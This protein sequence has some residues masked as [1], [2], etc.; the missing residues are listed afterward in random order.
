MLLPQKLRAKFTNR[1]LQIIEGLQRLEKPSVLD[2]VSFIYEAQGSLGSNFLKSHELNQQNIVALQT[3]TAELR[4]QIKPEEAR[5]R[6]IEALKRSLAMASLCRHFFT[7]TQHL[8]FGALVEINRQ[9]SLRDAMGF[10]S[11]SPGALE[12]SLK[13]ILESG[14]NFPELEDM[15]AMSFFD[16]LEAQRMLQEETMG[17]NTPQASSATQV[18]PLR[19]SSRSRAPLPTQFGEDL[20]EK[21][22]R[23]GLDPLIGRESEV[24]RILQI[25][26]RRTKSNPLLIGEA[27]V[28]KTAVIHGLAQRIASGEV[29]AN[30]IN[31]RV[32][33]LRLS[34][35][36]AGTMFRG[37]FESRLENVLQE[38][39][40][41]EVILFIDE[42]HNIVGAGSAQ[43]SL[44]AANILKPPLAQGQ[45]QVI[46]ATTLEEYRRHIERDKALER[47]FQPILVAEPTLLEAKKILSGA[48]PTYEKYHNVVISDRAVEAAVEL[49]SRYVTDRFLPDK[50]FDLL[51]EAAARLRSKRLHIKQMTEIRQLNEKLLAS[52]ALKER[53]IERAD[54]DAAFRIKQEEH[55]MRARMTA[56]ERIIHEK[57]QARPG[58]IDFAEVAAVVSEK[59]GV[60]LAQLGKSD[61]RRLINLESSLSKKVIGQAEAI[62]TL[63]RAIRRS[64]TGVGRP[65][66]PLGSFMFLGPTGVGKTSLT[67]HL[68]SL[69]FGQGALIKLDMSEFMEP[70]SVARLL[71]APAGYVGY[72]EGNILSKT[73]R[74]R[75]YSVVLFDEI[76]KAHP[77][78]HNI[79]LQILED[80]RITDAAGLEVSFENTIIVLTSN[81]GTERFTES[82]ALGFAGVDAPHQGENFEVLEGETI[83]EL[84]ETLKPELLDRLDE[85]VIFKPL[86][87]LEMKA[88][89]K[90]ELGEL[91][92]RLGSD[93]GLKLKV[94][95]A[96][97]SF[98][99]N[100][101]FKPRQGARLVSR[102]IQ[103]Q[104]EDLV[105]EKLVVNSLKPGQVAL[106]EVAPSGILRLK[107]RSK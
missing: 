103:R 49:S 68:A 84:R 55:L 98:L 10:L 85:V 16:E 100:E 21:A 6:I 93:L 7:G 15:Q 9:A 56:L 63:A 89:I 54:Y 101:S 96:A 66:R 86:G 31:K 36:V 91:A 67:R 4:E 42:I 60:P 13:A 82:A 75:P 34:L 14:S 61:K 37:E 2:M 76:E 26:C 105:A 25:L 24:D 79:L 95:P 87:R 43:G 72:G 97:L 74:H 30:L 69:V 99:L 57:S 104:V 12:K 81:I 35:L 29:P 5:A 70:H 102:V 3:L 94:A 32:Y 18:K 50:A 11:K 28:G 44:D 41:N 45:I 47:R 48:K 23:G 27:G 78:I 59:T 107:V 22:L 46:G 88:I 40:R 53:E 51:D 83:K 77:Q 65:H 20:T 39:K 19:R 62:N 58:T 80:G 106:I 64:R 8:L 71:G 1:A 90:K 52:H 38:A 17:E 92:T 73:L 33:D